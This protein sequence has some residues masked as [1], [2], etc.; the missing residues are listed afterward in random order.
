[1]SGHPGWCSVDSI[2][3]MFV[4]YV[5]FNNVTVGQSAS[6]AIA[7]PEAKVQQMVWITWLYCKDPFHEIPAEVQLSTSEGVNTSCSGHHCNL[8]PHYG[9]ELSF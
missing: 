7:S 5:G 8:V 1:M 4:L 9:V 2:I 6:I 3:N